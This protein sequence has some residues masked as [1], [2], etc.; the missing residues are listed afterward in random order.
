MRLGSGWKVENRLRRYQRQ[1]P[2]RGNGAKLPE[3]LITTPEKPLCAASYRN[4]D[5]SFK[6][7]VDA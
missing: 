7:L 4:A 1:R 5:E 3:T 2:A 6:H